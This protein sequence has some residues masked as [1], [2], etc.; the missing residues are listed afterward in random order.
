M[1]GEMGFPAGAPVHTSLPCSSL[2]IPVELP[3]VQGDPALL[4]EHSGRAFPPYKTSSFSCAQ[5]WDC[6]S[7]AHS[8]ELAPGK[9]LFASSSCSRGLGRKTF[10]GCYTGSLKDLEPEFLSCKGDREPVHLPAGAGWA[11]ALADVSWVD[12]NVRLHRKSSLKTPLG[13]RFRV[14]ITV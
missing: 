13:N 11:A 5:G 10:Y 3:E 2:P 8:S 4:W 6:G 9:I 14:E 1:T 12:M 7:I